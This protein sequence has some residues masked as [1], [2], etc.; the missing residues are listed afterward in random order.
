M[1]RPVGAFVNMEDFPFGSGGDS[2][3]RGTVRVYDQ[4]VVLLLVR[5]KR[6]LDEL[7][8]RRRI[9]RDEFL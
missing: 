3:R 7:G 2:M 6:D 1:D 4:S 8:V 9:L 5:R